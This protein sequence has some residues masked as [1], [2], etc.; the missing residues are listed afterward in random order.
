MDIGRRHGGPAVSL[1]TDQA[2][3]WRNHGHARIVDHP[4]IY[5]RGTAE[6]PRRGGSQGG[7]EDHPAPGSDPF[8]RGR[9][10]RPIQ[11]GGN[12]GPGTAR[13]ARGSTLDRLELG[14]VAWPRGTFIW[15]DHGHARIVDH[16][17]I[18]RRGTA[19]GTARGT[20]RGGSQGGE[21][22]HLAP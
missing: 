20:R 10:R 4:G 14:P 22:D 6:G 9:R 8:R 12:L 11:A 21:E 1:G 16:P 18:Y 13:T 17:G 15:R 19:E 7:E 2:L 3:F 5:R